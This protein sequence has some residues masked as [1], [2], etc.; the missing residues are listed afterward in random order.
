MEKIGEIE[1]HIE[2]INAKN[3]IKI[4]KKNIQEGLELVQKYE[5]EVQRRKNLEKQQKK[6]NPTKDSKNKNKVATK[7]KNKLSDKTNHKTKK[8]KFECN[9]CRKILSTKQSL[10]R[11]KRTH[12]G[13]K[14]YKC[15]LCPAMFAQMGHLKTHIMKTIQM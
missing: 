14:P 4:L 6:K 2:V 5:A 13:E 11:H 15:K 8:T 12:T 1:N 10:T 7:S 9:D 3:K